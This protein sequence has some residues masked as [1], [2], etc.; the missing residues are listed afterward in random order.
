MSRSDLRH[1]CF[2][3]LVVKRR[4]QRH[5]PAPHNLQVPLR[6]EDQ[7]KALIGQLG[8]QARHAHL[9][10]NHS[11]VRLPPLE[12]LRAPANSG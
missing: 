5:V 11:R 7:R 1:P 8:I 10:G 6:R 3:L 4:Q 9:V 2:Q 12:Q